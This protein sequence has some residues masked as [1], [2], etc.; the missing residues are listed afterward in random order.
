MKGATGSLESLETYDY[1]NAELA[2][3]DKESSKKML[4]KQKALHM[5]KV[6]DPTSLSVATNDEYKP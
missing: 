3:L 4:H 5:T 2:G 1:N 6:E